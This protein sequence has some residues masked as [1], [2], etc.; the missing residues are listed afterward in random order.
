MLDTGLARPPSPTY[1]AITPAT[2]APERNEA[3]AATELPAEA[4]VRPSVEAE[5]GQGAS[6]RSNQEQS[7]FADN[8]QKLDRRNVM[9]PQSDTMVYIATNTDTGEVVRQVPSE[10]L[11]KLRA[12]SKSVASQDQA[13]Q[14]QGFQRTV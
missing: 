8:S 6:G 12:Y 11:L 1:T 7:Q 10:T 5:N 9:D 3:A 2:R 4:T 13:A 14:S